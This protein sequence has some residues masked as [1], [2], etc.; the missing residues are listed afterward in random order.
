MTGQQARQSAA[1]SAYSAAAA[2]FLAAAALRG[3][4]IDRA[5]RAHTGELT[6]A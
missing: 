3:V 6:R 4:D 5:L 2:R 1:Q